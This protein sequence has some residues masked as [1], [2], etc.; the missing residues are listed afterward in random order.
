LIVL[1][2]SKRIVIIINAVVVIVVVRTGQTGDEFALTYLG[3]GK[4]LGGGFAQ[5]QPSFFA[6]MAKNHFATRQQI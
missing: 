3:L 4:C 2:A 6:C 5:M 1:I